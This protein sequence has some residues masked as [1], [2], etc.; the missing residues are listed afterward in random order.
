MRRAD[1]LFRGVLPTVVCLYY[2]PHLQDSLDPSMAVV[3]QEK[4]NYTYFDSW[5][6]GTQQNESV[7]DHSLMRHD[8]MS[9]S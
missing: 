3:Q 8:A 2:K 6:M 5:V 4:E 9:S 1:H 7:Y